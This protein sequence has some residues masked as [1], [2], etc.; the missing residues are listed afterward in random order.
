MIFK[1][2]I[3]SIEKAMSMEKFMASTMGKTFIIYGKE[4][5]YHGKKQLVLNA[6][7]IKK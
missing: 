7:S 5:E 6:V 3:T 1:N 4:G 2:G